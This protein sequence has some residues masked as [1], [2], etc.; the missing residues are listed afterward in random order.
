MP[1]RTG[2]VV[3]GYADNQHRDKRK[4]CHEAD[5]RNRGKPPHECFIV[6][7]PFK[8][9]I[10]FSLAVRPAQPDDSTRFITQVSE[11][12]KPETAEGGM[13]YDCSRPTAAWMPRSSLHGGIHS[14]F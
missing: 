6:Y 1:P 14:M 7:K 9:T 12:K 3:S 10:A 5:N 11:V 4:G 2:K 8:H 13:G